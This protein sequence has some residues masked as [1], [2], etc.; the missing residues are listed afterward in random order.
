MILALAN[1]RPE[2]V[3][4]LP[5][6]IAK[7]ELGKIEG[8]V[9]FADLMKRAD[10]AALDL[11]TPAREADAGAPQRPGRRPYLARPRAGNTLSSQ[12]S[13]S[14]A[15]PAGSG[16]RRGWK[17]VASYAATLPNT[18]ASPQPR[19]EP[20]HDAGGPSCGWRT[21]S[22]MTAWAVR[23]RRPWRYEQGREGSLTV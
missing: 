16:G 11:R 14:V 18:P 7:L 9:L 6:V 23:C 5:I 20:P 12:R 4:V 19:H 17:V 2:D 21:A 22:S 13:A 8:Q 1:S 15:H 10:T 3:S